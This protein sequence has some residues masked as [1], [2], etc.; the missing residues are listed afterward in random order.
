MSTR[1]CLYN[2]SS[3]GAET[4]G[5]E[6]LAATSLVLSSVRDPVSKHTLESI[7]K[8]TWL[9]SLAS[10]YTTCK[11]AR[12]SHSHTYMHRHAKTILFKDAKLN[13]MKQPLALWIRIGNNSRWIHG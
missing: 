9:P 8:D 5:Q 13:I 7:E 1:I 3:V 2:P 4:M 6:N 11:H 12:T 10:V